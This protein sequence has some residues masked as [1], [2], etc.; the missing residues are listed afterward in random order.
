MPE[1]K[2]A[3]TMERCYHCHETVPP[4]SDYALEANGERRSFCCPGCRAVAE[5]ISAEG[6]ERFYDFRT[7]PALKPIERNQTERPWSVCDRPEVER[8]LVKSFG[9][10]SSEFRFRIDGVN[11]AA[12]AWLIDR[13]L[14]SADGVEDVSINP[15][16]HEAR[17]VFDPR[18]LRVSRILEAVEHFGFVPRPGAG[19]DTAAEARAARDEL[20]RLA[21]AGLGFAQVMTL[22]TA[23]YL[24]AF[25]AM[26]AS[27]SSFFV[28]ASMLIA[29]PVVLY[30]GAPIFRS[31]VADVA[32]GRL[33]M[34]VPVSLAIVIALGASLTN[35]F[36]G[37]G[38]VYFDSATMFVFFLTLGR[39]LEARARH[40][41]GGFVA[42]LADVKPL[43][44]VRRFNQGIERV[45][46]IELV[47]GDVVIVAPG[48]AVPADGELVSD[49]GVLDESLLSGESLGRRRERGEALLG[50]SLNLGRSPLEVRVTQSENEGY[51]DRVSDLLHRA[52]ADRPEFL[53]LA[54]RWAGVFVAAVLG[55]TIA[56]GGVWMTLD[57]GRAVEVVL[58][59][60]VV[61]C[62]CALSLAAPTAF[63]VAL[64]RYARIGLLCRSARVIERVSEVTTWLFDKTGT[65]TEGRIGIVRV[66]R[67]TKLSESSCLRIASSLEAGIEH[68]IARAIRKLADAPPAE[69]VDY[70]AGFGVSGRV[71]GK[72]YSLGSAQHVGHDV[73]GDDAPCIY[74]SDDRQL[75]ARFVLADRMRPFAREALASL[76]GSARVA[77]IS[78]DSET[79]VAGAAHTLG[80]SEYRASLA[81]RA[82]LDFLRA[83][84][85]AGEVVAAVGDGIN[86]APFL[87]QADVS[88]AMVAGSQLAQASADIVFTGDDLRTLARLPELARETR[89]VVRQNLGWAAAYNL[90]VIPLAA[91]GLLMPWMAA[92]GMSLSSLVV[93][94]NSLRLSGLEPE[95]PE[96]PGDE[97][98]AI[99]VGG[100]H[101]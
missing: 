37:A 91:L 49:A 48:E 8:R 79:A 67:L 96:T 26:E 2:M 5:L 94:G 51:I 54:D 83:R 12:C 69:A 76:S 17:V 52:M 50:G 59:M 23:L 92:L 24:G 78:G 53:R 33:G 71:G 57:P 1:L 65:L 58:A 10:S 15:V 101:G 66:D 34:D 29:T 97:P 30:S 41:A 9:P 46:T 18:K 14:R 60:L 56:T 28:L 19:S 93:V 82:K 25:K 61:T 16:T 81:P 42:A 87:A 4:G 72:L 86:D 88:I 21:V 74:L 44:A 3:D 75:V 11:C 95:N 35:T 32:R 45:G 63:A 40:K 39:F 100:L 84:Q 55:L 85:Q 89:R 62:P 47:P 20:K 38:H 13:G 98:A 43:S 7:A 31:A 77:L 6:L 27:F 68:P 80:V 70:T 64:G 36:R 73:T 90:T 99:P 22:S